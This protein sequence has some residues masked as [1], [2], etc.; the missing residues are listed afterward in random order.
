MCVGKSDYNGVYSPIA[1]T[2]SGR[3]WYRNENENT[4]YFDPDCNSGTEGTAR[5]IFD[6][7][8]P[9]VTAEEDLDGEWR[10]GAE[11]RK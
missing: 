7:S 11:E 9:S 5:W 4:L 1:F 3:P 6:D 8:V 2:A 10:R